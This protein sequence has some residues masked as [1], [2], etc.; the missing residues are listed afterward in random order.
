MQS[1]KVSRWL[2]V[3]LVCGV[4]FVALPALA[5]AQ[6]GDFAYIPNSAEASVSKVNVDPA[7]PPGEIARYST[8]EPRPGVYNL[9]DYRVSRL[10]LDSGGNAWALNTM[11][12]AGFAGYATAQGSVARINAQPV[13]GEVPGVTTSNSSA[14]VP[15]DV[16]VS[17]FSLG[18]PGDSPRTI[19]VVEQG[20]T[21]Y[22]WIGFYLGRY[23]EKYEYDAFAGTLTAVPGTKISVGNYTPYAAV[24]D[25]SG[26][27]WVV[28]RNA[29][30]YP[31]PAGTPGVFRFDTNNLGAGVETLP[32]NVPGT[33]G[34][35]PY[36]V[37]LKG[38]GSVWVSDGGD[39]TSTRERFF[40]VYSGSPV[41]VQYVSV[42][43]G[44]HAM[45]GFVEYAG[46][47]WATTING[48]VLRGTWDGTSWSFTPVLTGLG[49]LTGIGADASGYL[50]AV[51]LSSDDI[52]R[53][54][55][56]D[57]GGGSLIVGVGDQPYAYGE[58]TVSDGCPP[59]EGPQYVCDTLPVSLKVH[60]TIWM[61]TS[62][63]VLEYNC[64]NPLTNS[65]VSLAFDWLIKSNVPWWKRIEW[66]GLAL[67]TYD[68]QSHQWV[69]QPGSGYL[70]ESFATGQGGLPDGTELLELNDSVDVGR[71]SVSVDG[72]PVS[73][74]WWSDVIGDADTHEDTER[75]GYD[76]DFGWCDTA[77]WYGG[78]IWL[79]AFQN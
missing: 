78:Y 3:M 66:T 33:T 18:A 41:S 62:V 1:I 79:C 13:P 70:F 32:Y 6:A 68:E 10:A 47:I 45:R 57:P 16:R 35:N 52:Y 21:V 15:N 34:D 69:T 7:A 48:R 60:P 12:G 11:T 51:R 61:G 31:T 29:S 5:Y 25:S 58:F 42:G 22:L 56:A 9:A 73:N 74:P 64:A 72:T 55:P 63:D 23:F 17:R 37:F 40:A 8:I 30:P 43:S 59:T 71:V 27:M 49:E 24:L 28:S 4:L 19:S 38:D 76:V 2:A 36:Y 53:F 75:V 54:D 39:W 77:G 14:I 67:G 46:E 50:W 65:S 20:G 44:S 26:M